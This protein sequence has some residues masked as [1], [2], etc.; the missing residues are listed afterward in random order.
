MDSYLKENRYFGST[1]GRCCNR[2]AKGKFTLNGKEFS[3][4]VNN[5][6]NHLHGGLKGFDKVIWKATPK[7]PQENEVS[8]EFF[9]HS[10]DGEEGYPGNLDVTVT[11][12]LTN[13]NEVQ[14]HF[15]AVTDKETIINLTNHAY[16]NLSGKNRDI[17][18]HI[19]T[20]HS[21]SFIPTD[22]TSIPLGHFQDVS[23]TPFDFREPHS[24]GEKINETHPQLLLGKGYDHTWIINRE[25]SNNSLALAATVFEPTTELKMEVWTTQPGVQLYT[26]NYLREL[27]GKNGPIEKRYGFCLETQHFPDSPN[28]SNFPSIVLLPSQVYQQQTI[29]KFV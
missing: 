23:G 13:D 11:Y 6:P 21:N 29:F 1:V 26:G 17:L 4:A 25:S 16:F 15:H 9:Y 2:I 28:R 12:T 14:I 3:L 7:L 27:K 10:K 19:L 18:D 5:D 8:I 20:I 24:I 22:E